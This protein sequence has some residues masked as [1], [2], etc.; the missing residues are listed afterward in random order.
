M[1]PPLIELTL[2]HGAAGGP[3][4][5]RVGALLLAGLILGAA[6][7]STWSGVGPARRPLDVRNLAA[8]ASQLT[9]ELGS[10]DDRVRSMLIE[11]RR[12]L[13][14]RPLDARAR[15]VYAS[16]LLGLSR[17][18]EHGEAAAFHAT[19]AARLAPVTVHVVRL[20]ALVLARTGEP[21]A[22]LGMTRDMF[23]YDRAAAATL[24]AQLEPLLDGEPFELALP[25]EPAAWLAWATA[26]R[27]HDRSDEAAD[28]LLRSHER[29]PDHLPTLHLLA[30]DAAV[31]ER[32]Q[33][34]RQL[35]PATLGL[36]ETREAAP[37]FALRARWRAMEHDRA[38]GS[39]DLERALRLDFDSG[40]V[41][42]LAGEACE[43][44]GD[45]EQ[46]RRLWQRALHEE[47][48]PRAR[49]LYL[50][51]RLEQRHG[52]PAAALRH[53]QSLLELEPQHAEAQRRV[54]DLTGFSR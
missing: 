7:L 40:H 51:A 41:Q 6:I 49:L 47:S 17:S 21:A 25:Q 35:L 20:A 23:A 36:A 18:P 34:L 11:L 46:A 1:H 48:A 5:R 30:Y 12:H 33:A 16:L 19:R 10:A 29:W 54:D 9:V 32:W 45:I 43:S 3:A 27:E 53:W 50:L 44:L 14:R 37:L 8:E 26:L 52:Q 31:R 13:G 2:A 24:L 28:W 15:A 22:A 42:M 39:R 4:A 38:G